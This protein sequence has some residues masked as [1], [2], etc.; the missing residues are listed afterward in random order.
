MLVH[1]IRA[2]TPCSCMPSAHAIRACLPLPWLSEPLLQGWG[3]PTALLPPPAGPAGFHPSSTAGS[4]PSPVA[5]NS[6]GECARAPVTSLGALG[7][8]Q[9]AFPLPLLA[10][11]RPC[12]CLGA[13][14]R[15]S[16]ALNQPLEFP[17][18]PQSNFFSLPHSVWSEF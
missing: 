10:S 2:S 13:R 6:M 9:I 3:K 4:V 18:F 7:P 16:L 5:A 1:A 14:R 17:P 8:G 11:S 12:C 15:Q